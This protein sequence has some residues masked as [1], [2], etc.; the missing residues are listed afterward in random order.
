ME[1]YPPDFPQDAKDAVELARLESRRVVGEAF[2]TSR[3]DDAVK[4]SV[5]RIF[6]A[7]GEQACLLVQKRTWSA[8][9][10]K[11]TFSCII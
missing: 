7:F 10:R 4:E 5:G 2:R 3:F 9:E 1:Y 8:P 11:Q 6:F